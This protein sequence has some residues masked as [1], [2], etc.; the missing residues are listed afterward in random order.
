METVKIIKECN[1]SM[2]SAL[3]S[4]VDQEGQL[5]NELND[6][7]LRVQAAILGDLEL[8]EI[9]EENLN[10]AALKLSQFLERF[11]KSLSEPSDDPTI[12]MLVENIRQEPDKTVKEWEAEIEELVEAINQ[13]NLSDNPEL[14]NVIEDILNLLSADY[15]EAV[16]ALYYKY[17]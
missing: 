13:K 3:S 17:R 14:L 15:S 8:L 10:G 7:V 2:L 12:S 9:S 16:K 4:H 6:S 11:K 5:L 1:M